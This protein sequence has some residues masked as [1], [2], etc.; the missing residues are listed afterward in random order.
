MRTFELKEVSK[1]EFMTPSAFIFLYE[2]QLFLTFRN[3]TV[4]VWN[5]RGHRVTSFEDH[6]LWHPDSDSNNIYITDDQDL[7]IS[8]CKADSDDPLSEGTGTC[9]SSLSFFQS[10]SF[11]FIFPLSFN[12]TERHLCASCTN[13]LSRSVLEEN[14]CGSFKRIKAA[15]K[16]FSYRFLTR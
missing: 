4:A 13:Y 9:F 14:H 11:I 5:L 7:I 3:R 1:N 16:K 10:C 12:A 2:N 8:Y 15:D 6:L